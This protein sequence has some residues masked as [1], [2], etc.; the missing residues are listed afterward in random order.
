MPQS[1]EYNFPLSLKVSLNVPSSPASSPYQCLFSIRTLFAVP[2]H[3]RHLSSCCQS[4]ACK[5]SSAR[6]SRKT[7]YYSFHVFPYSV[8]PAE[9]IPYLAF[10][11]RPRLTALTCMAS[12]EFKE[13]ILDLVLIIPEICVS[14][15]EAFLTFSK[16]FELSGN[17]TKNHS[18]ASFF[19]SSALILLALHIT[20]CIH[21]ICCICSIIICLRKLKL[22]NYNFFSLFQEYPANSNDNFS[23]RA[24]SSLLYLQKY[25]ILIT[26]HQMRGDSH[27]I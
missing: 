7:M 5:T 24:K 21:L 3:Y 22:T 14:S 6:H 16:N 15:V 4:E 26:R 8:Q 11:H 23:V 27:L 12:S 19:L 1:T 9:P 20:L 17:K 25:V 13:C 10:Q 18:S 2:S